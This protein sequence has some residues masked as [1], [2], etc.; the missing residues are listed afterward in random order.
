MS[1]PLFV[2]LGHF[3]FSSP[4][5]AINKASY[6]VGSSF[7]KLT[8]FSVCNVFSFARTFGENG[9]T[10]DQNGRKMADDQLLFVALSLFRILM[11][12]M[13]CCLQG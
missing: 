11:I 8:V 3:Q 9:Q 2:T 13:R 12:F 1:L 7:Y 10:F 4:C 6:L 5:R